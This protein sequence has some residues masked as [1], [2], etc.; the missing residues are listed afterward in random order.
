[1][2]FVRWNNEVM[3]FNFT[4]FLYEKNS[5]FLFYFFSFWIAYLHWVVLQV[6]FFRLPLFPKF[7]KEG[8]NTLSSKD[9][10]VHWDA[11]KDNLSALLH[12]ESTIFKYFTFPW[13]DLMEKRKSIYSC[14]LYF[15]TN[16]R[17]RRANA[18]P[19][20]VL[21]LGKECLFLEYHLL[22]K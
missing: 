14:H 6:E 3:F 9:V 18:S 4:F 20:L 16:F 21:Y 11:I 22:R 17:H 2:I 10:C 12:T 8:F 5:N 1:M 15:R 13:Q 7:S 19:I